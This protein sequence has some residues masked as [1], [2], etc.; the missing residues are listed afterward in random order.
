[1]IQLI[2]LLVKCFVS[3]NNWCFLK[4]RALD[5]AMK[6]EALNKQRIQYNTYLIL[7]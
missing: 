3:V 5:R 1:M 2:S 7:W 4:M 6:K